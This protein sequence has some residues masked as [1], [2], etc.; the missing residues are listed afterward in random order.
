MAARAVAVLSQFNR[1]AFPEAHHQVDSGI[2]PDASRA[3]AGTTISCR[4]VIL[5][6]FAA[7]ARG[8]GDASHG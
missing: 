8:S 1:M 4:N 7:A 3:E 2:A 6:A 5:L